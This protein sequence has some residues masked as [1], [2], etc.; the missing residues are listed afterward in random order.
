MLKDKIKNAIKKIKSKLSIEK[1]VG[2]YAPLVPVSELE[3]GSNVIIEPDIVESPGEEVIVITPND[4]QLENVTEDDAQVVPA[5][6]V[7][8]IIP[9]SIVPEEDKSINDSEV[10]VISTEGPTH[11]VEAVAPAPCPNCPSEEEYESDVLVSK[12]DQSKSQ[13]EPHKKAEVDLDIF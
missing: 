7:D 9:D 8:E 12:E 6:S 5:P 10:V 1:I 11:N 3:S 4:V 2:P 13:E